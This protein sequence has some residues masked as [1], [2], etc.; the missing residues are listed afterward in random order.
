LSATLLLLLVVPL[1]ASAYTVVMR[2]GRRI[3]IPERFVVTETT[4]TYEVSPGIS[5]TLQMS[6]IDIA[7]TERA[8]NEPPGSLLER[9]G[10]QAQNAVNVQPTRAARTITNRDLDATRRAREASEAAYERRRRELGLPTLE[11]SRRRAEAEARVAR[12][13]LRRSMSEEAQN[14]EYWRARAAELREQLAALDAQI[15]YVRGLLASLPDRPAIGSYTVLTNAFPLFP[16]RGAVGFP[17]FGPGQRAPLAGGIARRPGVF[18]A[19]NI[20]PQL[21]ARLSLGGGRTRGQVF[22]N[23]SYPGRGLGHPF[24]HGALAQPFPLL[25]Y[26]YPDN[27]LY[28]YD[29]ASL[30]E[31]LRELE[32]ERAGFQ[33]RWRVLEDEA[34]RAGALPGWLRP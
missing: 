28:D 19:P 6:A 32:L 20:G 15:D 21:T 29:R 7:A 4:L 11:E 16:S 31:R 23:P 18:V 2:G 13:E 22:V 14:E 25:G 30:L 8:N 12:E 10:M 27:S 3:E 17:H 24:P 26:T 33:A 1:A 5:I 9:A 34:R